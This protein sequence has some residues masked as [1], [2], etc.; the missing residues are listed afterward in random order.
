MLFEVERKLGR[1]LSVS[2]RTVLLAAPPR[3]VFSDISQMPAVA[4][5]IADVLYPGQDRFLPL[6][7]K[8]GVSQVLEPWRLK[9]LRWIGAA[10]WLGPPVVGW[11]AWQQWQGELQAAQ[12]LPHYQPSPPLSILVLLSLSLCLPGVVSQFCQAITRV[13]QPFDARRL[14]LQLL[15]H[16]DEIDEIYQRTPLL[17][18]WF[19]LGG[20]PGR[21]VQARTRL[22]SNYLD[23]YLGPRKY[24]F[25]WYWLQITVSLIAPAALTFWLGSGR[26]HMLPWFYA[27]VGPMQGIIWSGGFVTGQKTIFRRVLLRELLSNFGAMEAGATE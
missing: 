12:Q 23:W 27:F 16:G 18:R 24:H 22:L 2:E 1:P 4:R 21:T 9:L 5:E 26:H 15:E 14:F 17:W 13:A 6:P 8:G 3:N 19:C 7:G 10:L 20:T 25:R 11:M